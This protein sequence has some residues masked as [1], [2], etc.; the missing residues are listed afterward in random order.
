M[1][2]TRIH[3]SHD[4]LCYVGDRLRA[5]GRTPDP[6]MVVNLEPLFEGVFLGGETVRLD[7]ILEA[8][9]RGERWLTPVG[10]GPR[11]Y[12]LT[13]PGA[14]VARAVARRRLGRKGLLVLAG[15]AA[16]ALA[17]YWFMLRP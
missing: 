13:A 16:L 11:R 7:R 3:D 2:S 6:G 14:A 17:G 8:A 4:L 10:G 1:T 15:L 9:V 12:A 5:E